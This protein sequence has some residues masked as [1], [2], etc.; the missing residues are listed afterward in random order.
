[1]QIGYRAPHNE[2]CDIA[3]NLLFRSGIVVNRCKKGA[4]HEQLHRW[5]R[6]ECHW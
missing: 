5:R 4:V 1:M 6:V 3:G 2:D